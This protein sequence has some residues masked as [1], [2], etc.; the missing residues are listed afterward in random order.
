LYALSLDTDIL[1]V[2]ATQEV[3]ALLLS[4]RAL[5]SQGLPDK[6]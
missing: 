3:P 1:W 5:T 4:L 2:A 6:N